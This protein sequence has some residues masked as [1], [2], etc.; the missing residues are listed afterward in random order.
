MA[1]NMLTGEGV[2]G[3][4]LNVKGASPYYMSPDNIYGL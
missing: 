1:N 4:G 3:K 2:D